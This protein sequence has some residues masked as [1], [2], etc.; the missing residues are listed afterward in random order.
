MK[1]LVGI[2]WLHYREVIPERN[3]QIIFPNDQTERDDDDCIAILRSVTVD[4][5]HK[6]SGKSIRI[7]VLSQLSDSLSQSKY[8][9]T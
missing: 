7:N 1:E 3:M 9:H 5:H 4:Q 8:I 2:D 6:L